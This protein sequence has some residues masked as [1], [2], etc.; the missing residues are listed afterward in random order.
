MRANLYAKADCSIFDSSWECVPTGSKIFIWV[1]GVGV[2]A[3]FVL[4][5][6]AVVSQVTKD[7]KLKA[8]LADPNSPEAKK[9]KLINMNL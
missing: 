8:L 2:I 5:F 7:A 3:F 4:G 6:L 1:L 9:L